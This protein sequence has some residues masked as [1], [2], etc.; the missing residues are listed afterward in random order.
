[1]IDTQT[2]P[3]APVTLLPPPAAAPVRIAWPREAA[4][5]PGFRWARAWEIAFGI[6]LA[7]IAAALL[8]GVLIVL[9]LAFGASGASLRL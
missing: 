9:A 5:T 2:A 4:P 6:A 3:A 7:P 1:M 8:Y